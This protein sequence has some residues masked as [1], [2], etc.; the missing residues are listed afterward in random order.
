MKKTFI[1]FFAPGTLFNE[2]WEKESDT[3]DPYKVVWPDSAY[4][5]QIFQRIDIVDGGKVFKGEEKQVGPTY[6]HPDSRIET[7]AQVKRNPAAT[8]ILIRNMKQNKWKKVVWAR[9]N[10][11]PQPFGKG[12]VVLDKRKAL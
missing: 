8:D 10:S 3:T 7:L 12:V 4:A 9:W 6:F 5:F 2:S 11:W 1:M